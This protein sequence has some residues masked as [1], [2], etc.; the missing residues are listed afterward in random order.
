MS[1]DPDEPPTKSM[2]RTR[3]LYA[4]VVGCSHGELD[5]IY[6]RIAAEESKKK[7]KIDLLICCGDFQVGSAFR[8]V[9]LAAFTTYRQIG[10]TAIC[11]ISTH[12]IITG[13]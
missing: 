8:I 10:I 11:I 9:T 12:H 2:R 4:A 7:I 1:N 6:Q 3:S 5:L 13:N